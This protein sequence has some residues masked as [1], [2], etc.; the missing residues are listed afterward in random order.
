IA[1][2]IASPIAWYIMH[3]WMQDYSYQIGIQWWVFLLTAVVAI[4]ITVI[5][6]GWQ[7]IKAALANPVNSLRDE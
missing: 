2:L 3:K 4:T 7:S 6:I 5:T 1:I